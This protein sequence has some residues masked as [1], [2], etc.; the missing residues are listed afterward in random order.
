MRKLFIT[1]VL[2]FGFYNTS[3]SET[4]NPLK[5]F[6]LQIDNTRFVLDTVFDDKVLKYSFN[7]E[8]TAND[9][10]IEF[11][12][13]ITLRDKDNFKIKNQI[14][15][16]MSIGAGAKK[17]Y[18]SN[19]SFISYDEWNETTSII[20]ELNLFGCPMGVLDAGT[21][22][23]KPLELKVEN[24]KIFN[25][26]KEMILVGNTGN[27]SLKSNTSSTSSDSSYFSQKYIYKYYDDGSC[28][29]GE[30]GYFDKGLITKC[31]GLDE[32][33]KL[34][35]LSKSI[36]QGARDIASTYH[37]GT[38]S[39]FIKSGSSYRGMKAVWQDTENK[40]YARWTISGILNGTSTS[41][42]LYVTAIE[43]INVDNEILI[44]NN[45]FLGM[46]D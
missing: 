32:Y 25:S 37:S 42:T 30:K 13:C 40:C 28:S 44:H 27:N 38:L 16:S 24:G 23:L 10:R 11:F 15:P 14:G 31:I 18:S 43:F 9:K 19:V 45:I 39:S 41:K 29:N 22:Y 12:A 35:K 17:I 36:T 46:T 3:Y 26:K 2:L 8:N 34:C 5:E 7:I 21:A 4:K 6:P 33:K 20:I 1:F